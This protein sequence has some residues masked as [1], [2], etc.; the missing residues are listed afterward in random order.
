MSRKKY[1]PEVKAV[2]EVLKERKTANEIAKQFEVHPTML[3]TWKKLLVDQLPAFFADP[4]S[5][6]STERGECS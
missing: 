5:R 1:T 2:L 4:S 6:R 3:S